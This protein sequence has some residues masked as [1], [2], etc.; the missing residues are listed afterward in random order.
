MANINQYIPQVA[1]SPEKS[2]SENLDEL[3]MG[4]KE[5]GVRSGKPK[6]QL[7]RI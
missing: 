7:S 1:F 5:F 4:P 6:K 3:G 2:F